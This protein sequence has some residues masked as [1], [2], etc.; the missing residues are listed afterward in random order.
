MNKRR[1]AFVLLACALVGMP[2]CY[3][4]GR[5]RASGVPSPNPM[6]YAGT[7]EDSG[8]PAN[9]AIKSESRCSMP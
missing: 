4:A 1:L 3:V 7:L 2:L 9:G 5:A 6:V 8:S